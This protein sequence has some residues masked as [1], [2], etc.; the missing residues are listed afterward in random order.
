[1]VVWLKRALRGTC[2]GSRRELM[3]D[4]IMKPFFLWAWTWKH[5]INKDFLHDLSSVAWNDSKPFTTIIK[6]L[7][8]W[9]PT[10][11]KTK[12]WI[13]LIIHQTEW[14]TE[15]QQLFHNKSESRLFRKD[16]PGKIEHS[17]D[18]ISNTVIWKHKTSAQSLCI[19]WSSYFE[20]LLF[21]LHF[22]WLVQYFII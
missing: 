8:G 9:S 17:H 3:S 20:N 11:S 6:R 21:V 7:I 14:P 22:V 16:I 13:H 10:W 1:M 15:V 19:F 12:L 2:S 5:H 4:E 18:V